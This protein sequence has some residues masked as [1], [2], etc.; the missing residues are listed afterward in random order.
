M[1][2]AGSS[3]FFL[4]LHL[5]FFSFMINV[6][7]YISILYFHTSLECIFSKDYNNILV[8]K[9]LISSNDSFAVPTKIEFCNF[10]ENIENT[11][12]NK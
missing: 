8:I 4:S 7:H 10:G 6:P 12:L 1:V 3:L 5:Q 9:S 11:A 2:K